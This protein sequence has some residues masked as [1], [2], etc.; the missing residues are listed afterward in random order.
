MPTLNTITGKK[1][2][3]VAFRDGEPDRH[4][5]LNGKVCVIGRSKKADLFI[6]DSTISRQHALVKIAN[7]NEL[8][9]EDC[10]S[11]NGVYVNG[12]Q[13]SASAI[14]EGDLITVGAYTLVVRAL[15]DT[16]DRVESVK[17]T[18]F[19]GGESSQRI[20]AA[21]KVKHS[22]EHYEALYKVALLLG[23]NTELNTLLREVLATVLEALPAMRGNLTVVSRDQGQR[24]INETIYLGEAGDFPDLPVALAT[25]V[26]NR[27]SPLLTRDAGAETR[28]PV[29]AVHGRSTWPLV[30]VPLCGTQ[31]GL[32]TIYFDGR[33]DDKPFQDR[34]LQF[35]TAVAHVI[36]VSIENRH[37]IDGIL[38]QERLAALGRGIAG[39][40]HDVRNVLIGIKVGAEMLSQLDSSAGQKHINKAVGII[41]KSADQVE[42]YLT[43]LLNFVRQNNV[44]CR[45][46]FVHGLLSDAIELVKPQAEELGVEIEYMGGGFEPASL[47][48]LQ[49]QRVVV[50]LLKNAVEACAGRDGKV[51]VTSEARSG[52]LYLRIRD[53]GTGIHQ[54]DL[55]HLF[56]PFFSKKGSAGTGLGLA[57]SSRIVE[58]H[59]GR[60]RVSSEV[61]KGTVFTI[62]LP[63]AFRYTAED[64]EVDTDLIGDDKPQFI[65]RGCNQVWLER[66][67]LIS[68]PAIALAGYQANFDNLE[69][70]RFVFTHE[71]GASFSVC[72]K[73]FLTLCAEHVHTGYRL[74]GEACPGYCMHEHELDP[75]GAECECAYIRNVLDV[76]RKW[77]K[78]IPAHE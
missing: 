30:C 53:N 46:T 74:N 25:Y 64:S 44:V 34:D 52:K 14:S 69:S 20:S 36:S 47:D 24:E 48:A 71:C 10:G 7:G 37:L 1:F 51:I 38:R 57:I 12:T 67:G 40:S 61:G 68:D 21:L 58:Q 54:Q 43:E 23:E 45:P 13:V 26:M 29:A 19:V 9:I 73:S 78:A 49:M 31:G 2:L 6:P 50:N 8:I 11:T 4:G 5:V 33:P 77:P 18:Q 62:I 75:C 27:R 39:I 22:P 15:D 56:E 59:G 17:E 16:T 3:V 60:I 55:E 63:N 28:I 72:V 66:E 76:V 35:L 65:C 70:G 41:R 32:G 42:T